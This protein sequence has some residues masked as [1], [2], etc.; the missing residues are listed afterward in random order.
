[1]AASPLE[2]RAPSSLSEA[3]ST[4]EEQPFD[5]PDA[6]IILRSSD[7]R[8]FRVLKSFIIKSS[9]ILDKLIQT[10]SDLPADAVSAGTDTPLPIVRMPESGAILQSL[11]TFI[12]PVPPVLPPGVEGTMELLPVAQKYEMGH[13]L[14]H[15]R[16]SI[17]LQDPPFIRESNALQVYSLAQKYGLRP[18]VVQAARL[19]LKFTLTIENLEG[20]LDTMRGDHLR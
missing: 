3:S 17:A 14:I 10:S 1:M 18:E 15:I 5:Y 19:T 7:S 13:I 2:P 8:D 20:K 4:E 11:L 16:G 6:D 12:L 9:P